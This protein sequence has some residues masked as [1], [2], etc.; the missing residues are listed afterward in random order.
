MGVMLK[1]TTTTS[2][3][4][5]EGRNINLGDDNVKMDQDNID[6]M[7]CEAYGVAPSTLTTSSTVDY[8]LVF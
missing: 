8:E 5:R 1:S 7:D 6:T 2:S 3:E 4:N